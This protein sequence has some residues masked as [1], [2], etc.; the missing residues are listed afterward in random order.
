MLLH[1]PGDLQFSVQAFPLRRL[2]ADCRGQASDL[3][4][5][6]G[7]DPVETSC[8][9]AFGELVGFNLVPGDQVGSETFLVSIVP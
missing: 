5:H 9:R 6:F 1:L 7:F 8:D 4:G 3:L 2:P